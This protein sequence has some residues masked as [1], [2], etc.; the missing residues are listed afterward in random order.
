MSRTMLW[1]GIMCVMGAVLR[2]AGAAPPAVP[3]AA[4]GDIAGTVTDSSNGNPIQGVEITIQRGPTVLASAVTDPFGRY[5]V[6][7]VAVGDYTVAAHFIGFHAMSRPVTVSGGKT[8]RVNLALASAPAELAKVTTSAVAPVSIDTRTGDQTFIQND[9]H[10]LPTTTT[11]QVLQQSIAGAARAPTG[12][13]HIRGQ[14]A[15][16][17]YYIDGLPVT[18]GVSG[19]LNE[20]F[21][22]NVIQRIDFI[23]G[24]W[25]AEYGEKSAAII[26][27]QS[28]IPTGA[29]HADESTYYGS[30]N[31]LGQTLN[32]SANQ[33]RWGEFLSGTAQGTDMRRE[34]VESDQYNHPDNF[35]NHGDDYFGFGKIQYT[36]PKDII[37]LD[38]N[39][40]MSWYQIPYDSSTGTILHDHETDINSFINLSYRHL[41]G[42]VTTTH[43]VGIPN[44]FFAGIFYRNGQLE[45]RPGSGDKP[46]FVDSL[47]DPTFTPRNVFEDRKFNT[48]GLKSDFG[49]PVVENL[50]D[51]KVGVLGS[52]TYGHENF[53]LT[54]PTGVQ[55]P[56]ESNSGLYGYDW[57]AYAETSVHPTEWFELRTGLRFNSHVAPYAPNQTQFS[58]RVRLNFFPDPSNTIYVYYGR[59]FLPTN[60]EDLR[61]ITLQ[62]GGGSDTSGSTLPERDN[63]YEIAYIHRFIG[64]NVLIKVDGYWKDSKPGID[65]N[66]IPGTSIT[67]DI[68]QG[69]SHVRGVE[70]VLNVT[71]PKS[72]L[73]GYINF[74]LNHG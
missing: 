50:M 3:H 24:G 7:E 27:I 42:D 16:Y 8:T 58:P 26:N 45:Y 5:V 11:S 35:S 63:F 31:S 60:I 46:S 17:T 30:F 55:G 1:V 53:S 49:F 21:D 15:E 28:K 2:T 36:A 66:T 69:T 62:S 65:D 4:S 23:T 51:A 52:Y 19:S 34:P 73:S 68:N 29:F 25:D 13:V 43:E 70:M 20:L 10:Y 38:G 57:A 47:D 48:I 9:A 41:I 56:I 71:P 18:S 61:K 32:L 39:Y 64:P 6:H 54:D 22:P 33:G 67:T 12:E 74:A 40:S 14:H 44:E 37:S 72:P 59:T